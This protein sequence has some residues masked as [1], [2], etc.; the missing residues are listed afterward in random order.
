MQSV[1]PLSVVVGAGRPLP[2]EEMFGHEVEH[3]PVG[4]ALLALAVHV[5][6]GVLHH[7]L[8]LLRHLRN[9]G[10]RRE[11]S[12]TSLSEPEGF[13]LKGEN[14]SIEIRRTNKNDI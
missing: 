5:S 7:L 12:T 10:R 8:H 9:N 13:Y 4:L 14:L 6:L 11:F 2:G 1:C 3:V